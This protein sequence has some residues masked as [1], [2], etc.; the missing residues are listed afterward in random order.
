MIR[1]PCS[2]AVLLIIPSRPDSLRRLPVKTGRGRRRFGDRTV[3]SAGIDRFGEPSL[4]PT[5]YVQPRHAG[6]GRSLGSPEPSCIPGTDPARAG[7]GPTGFLEIQ[8]NDL[9][10][11]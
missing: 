6:V 10:E 4:A 8:K 3:A 7:L 1:R 5:P 2:A 9:T 11:Q